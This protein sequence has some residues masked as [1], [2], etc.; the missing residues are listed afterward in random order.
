MVVKYIVHGIDCTTGEQKTSSEVFDNL[1][2]AV[3]HVEGW[4]GFYCYYKELRRLGGSENDFWIEKQ[5]SER[6]KL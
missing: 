5:T 1:N 6:V 3:E 4:L 2:D